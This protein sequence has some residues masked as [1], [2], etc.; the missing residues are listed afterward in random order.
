MP[1]D[2]QRLQYVMKSDKAEVIYDRLNTHKEIMERMHAFSCDVQEE[3]YYLTEEGEEWV[4]LEKDQFS[5]RYSPERKESEKK[6][7]EAAQ[8]W[9]KHKSASP[10]QVIRHI[11]AASATYY[12]QSDYFTA[13]DV[14]ISRSLLPGHTLPS[15]PENSIPLL[16]GEAAFIIFSF[17][18]SLLDFSAYQFHSKL[19][20]SPTETLYID[21]VEATYDGTTLTL[22]GDVTLQ[23]PLGLI[24]ANDIEITPSVRLGNPT[25]KK[26]YLHENVRL[27]LK[28]QGNFLCESALLE[29]HASEG[30]KGYF[31]GKEES[32]VVYRTQ[33][34]HKD[35][36]TVPLTL[37][38]PQMRMCMQQ[39]LPSDCWQIQSIQSNGSVSIEYNDDF[40]ITA[41]SARYE[42]TRPP[43]TDSKISLP[44]II[45]LEKDLLN[46]RCK[47]INQQGDLIYADHI[48][49][50]M[51]KKSL[52][53]SCSS[54]VLNISS[55]N[56]P[57][58][59][60]F[61]SSQMTW[62]TLT[63]IATLVGQVHLSSPNAQKTAQYAM[64]DRL[65]LFLKDRT[66]RL[67]AAPKKRVL[68]IDSLNDLQV[69]AP[70]LI[71]QKDAE[72]AIAIQGEGDVRF[73]FLQQE[74]ELMKNH[75]NLDRFLEAGKK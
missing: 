30:I 6:Q 48:D 67:S 47:V 57:E 65:D 39:E 53:F 44:G 54:G 27:Y 11:E 19:F 21:A 22:T 49:I 1:K 38:G 32:P 64:A 56:S 46:Q 43:L 58:Q 42:R 28:E 60:H 4:E 24:S 5:P 9:S 63:N 75:F 66:M 37:S 17:N 71:L 40:L 69:S 31:F 34:K 20:I 74:F 73:H 15:S 3:L 26:V 33:A 41:E 14:R 55:S 45:H 62:N 13:E 68:L 59:L 29:N 7:M 18:K 72:Q 10:M 16:S 23:H 61:S 2:A 35:G 12:Y 51:Q 52:A 36:L 25:L 50:D 70:S 8:F